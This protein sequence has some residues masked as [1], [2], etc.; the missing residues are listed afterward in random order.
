[1]ERL[2]M[3]PFANFEPVDATCLITEQLNWSHT[4]C[5]C[6]WIGHVYIV[7]VINVKGATIT[8]II[9]HLPKV[10]N[11]NLPLIIFLDFSIYRLNYCTLFMSTTTCSR[12]EPFIVAVTLSY[13]FLFLFVTCTGLH[14][15]VAITFASNFLPIAVVF[16]C[17]LHI[18]S[19]GFAVVHFAL[20]CAPYSGFFRSFVVAFLAFFTVLFSSFCCRFFV[21]Q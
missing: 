12:N 16:V 13:F 4:Q 21:F 14:I 19:L 11:F 5:V 1:M 20:A 17:L 15:V 6:A 18:S 8:V 3:W 9:D 10:I 2:C 7:Y